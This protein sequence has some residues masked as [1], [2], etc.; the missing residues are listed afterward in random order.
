MAITIFLQ[1]EEKKPALLLIWV[2]MVKIWLVNSHV[3]LY[4]N[5]IQRFCLCQIWKTQIHLFIL[6]E[7]DDE[8]DL[9]LNNPN[10]NGFQYDSTRSRDSIQ[11]NFSSEDTSDNTNTGHS[12]SHRSRTIVRMSQHQNENIRPGMMIKTR[13]FWI[14][15]LTFFLNTQ[16]I[17]Y[18]NAMYK[19]IMNC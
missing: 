10:S 8:E 3:F 4:N 2:E 19:V 18:I 15:W 12:S 1:K 7:E 13:E 5:F 11:R 14:L 16:S 6:G 17:G 9:E